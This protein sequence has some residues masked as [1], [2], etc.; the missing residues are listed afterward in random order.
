MPA[1]IR[2]RVKADGGFWR[3]LCGV[4]PGL[5]NVE[6]LERSSTSAGLY[7]SRNGKRVDIPGSDG[8]HV[9]PFVKD[10]ADFEQF[11]RVLHERCWLKGL[12][13]FVVGAAGQLLDRS[14]VDRMVGSPA[15]SR[16][17]AK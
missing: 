3:S 5:A 13:W 17:R 9:Y 10:G 16:K 1:E 6:R 7:Y 14:I 15:A 11:L 2:A 4:L 8:V 12:G